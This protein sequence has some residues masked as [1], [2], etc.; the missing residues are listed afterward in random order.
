MAHKKVLL[1]TCLLVISLTSVFAITPSDYNLHLLGTEYQVGDNSSV[2]LQLLSSNTG[3]AINDATCYLDSF[4]PN[5]SI[6]LNNQLMIY[7]TG[8]DGLYYHKTTIPNATGVYMFSS[9]CNIRDSVWSFFDSDYY[10]YQNNPNGNINLIS[11]VGTNTGSIT[12][13]QSFDDSLYFKQAGA[14]VGVRT[15]NMTL[16]FNLTS[17]GL[18]F[19]NITSIEIIYS[20][21]STATNVVTTS[22]FN[23]SSSR[24]SQLPN[25][26]TMSASA[27]TSEPLGFDVTSTN[28]VNNVNNF[29]NDYVSYDG[30]SQIIR[31]R[32]GTTNGGTAFTQYHNYVNLFVYPSLATSIGVR[33][34]SEWHVTTHLLETKGFLQEI[35]DYLTEDIWQKLLEIT[36]IVETNQAK[37]N[38]SLSEQNQTRIQI[39]NLSGQLSATNNSII[40]AIEGIN[41]S[42]TGN[43]SATADLTGIATKSDITALNQSIL[44]N[45]SAYWE[46]LVFG[47]SYG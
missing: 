7:Q 42:F 21:E 4:Y 36:G 10:P 1:L 2:F 37:L 40:T 43:V 47:E 5:N 12:N 3:Q 35:I 32:I 34:S 14:S 20:G 33:G 8:S 44:N 27:T 30:T 16:D 24:F 38:Q 6:H 18:N 17:A 46:S 28:L 25:T 19:S 26:A 41:V 23:F 39:A 31:I 29:F 13:V 9:T 15:A 22:V 45:Q 11:S